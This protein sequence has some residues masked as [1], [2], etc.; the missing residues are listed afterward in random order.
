VSS[1]GSNCPPEVY[2]P[3]RW[4]AEDYFDKLTEARTSADVQ[5]ADAARRKRVEAREVLFVSGTVRNPPP[6]ISS[7]VVGK[8]RRSSVDPT[9]V[10]WSVTCTPASQHSPLNVHFFNASLTL[11]HRVLAAGGSASRGGTKS[12]GNFCKE[13]Q[14]MR[15]HYQTA[16][17]TLPRTLLNTSLPFSI[18]AAPRHQN[19]LFPKY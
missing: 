14:S 19:K 18:E 9:K 5:R 4:G 6:V 13:R 3:K 12:R 8:S 15:S 2:D 17:H 7:L 16:T 10:R 1:P 11:T